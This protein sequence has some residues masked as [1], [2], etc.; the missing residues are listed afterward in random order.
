MSTLLKCYICD[1]TT[2]NQKK[3]EEH[4]EFPKIGLYLKVGEM[5]SAIQNSIINN[6]DPIEGHFLA[7]F[8]GNEVGWIGQ[9][10]SEDNK[11][12][13]GVHVMQ[14]NM[15]PFIVNSSTNLISPEQTFYVYKAELTNRK[16]EL[17]S[18]ELEKQK[19][20]L[21]LSQEEYESAL[22]AINRLLYQNIYDGRVSRDFEHI[23]ENFI[24]EIE[25]IQ[26]KIQM[27]IFKKD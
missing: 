11:H 18:Y 17:A 27:G 22:E 23:K 26:N 20:L 1:Y 12:Y 6:L 13:F 25:K 24:E 9:E 2:T 21:G 8:I 19:S 7:T 15:I 16:A 4:I 3:Y 14:H 5:F 10:I